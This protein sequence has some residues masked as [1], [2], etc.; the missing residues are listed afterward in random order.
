MQNEKLDKKEIL[1]MDKKDIEFEL[2]QIE[3]ESR[4]I[5][6]A[7]WRKKKQLR[8]RWQ[9]AMNAREQNKLLLES[10]EGEQNGK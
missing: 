2:D 1:L 6:I 4:G 7:A 3:L 10:L 5:E 8:T 9:D